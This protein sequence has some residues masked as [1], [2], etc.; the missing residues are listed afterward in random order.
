MRN[1][2]KII[3]ISFCIIILAFSFISFL[4]NLKNISINQKLQYTKTIHLMDTVKI[5][6]NNYGIP[7]IKAHSDND[8][9]FAVGYFHAKERLWQMDLA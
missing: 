5:F 4:V 6:T 1:I 8:L 9:F 3:I 2:Y 7:Y